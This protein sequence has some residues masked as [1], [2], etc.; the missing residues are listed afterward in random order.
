M[1]SLKLLLLFVLSSFSLL[2]YAQDHKFKISL[3]SGFMNGA[4]IYKNEPQAAGIED[5]GGFN[6]GVDI[7]YF[8]TKRFFAGVHF[9]SRR[10]YYFAHTW[11]FSYPNGIHYL[12]DEK[13]SG[14][15]RIN[16]IGLIAGYCLPVSSIVNLTGQIGFAQFIKNNIYPARVYYP[17]EE[18]EPNLSL[19]NSFD[20]SILFSASFPVKFNLGVTP[21][22]SMNI[23]FAKNIEIGYACGFYIEP[24]FGPF[25]GVYHGPQLS[26]MF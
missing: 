15:M 13:S 23:G 18:H 8:F 3:Q 26:V 21:F 7:T 11:D 2:S 1:N 10:M 5:D 24:D 14:N 6:I 19:G 12:L 25:T 20:E 9:N 17:D 4:D 22:K 16:N